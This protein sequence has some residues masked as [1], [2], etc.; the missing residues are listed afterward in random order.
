[1][2]TP[3][4]APRPIAFFD[5]DR[6]LVDGYTGYE[7]SRWLVRVGIFKRRRIAQA[8]FYK[9]LAALHAADAANVLR[10]YEIA[11]GDMAGQHIDTMR[12]HGRYVFDTWFAHRIFRQGLER[13]REH[14]ARGHEVVLLTSGPYMTVDV[15]HERLGTDVCYAMGPRLDERGV[16]LNEARLPI[17]VDHRKLDVAREH[18]RVRGVP[19]AA[20]TFY[21]DSMRDVALLREVGAPRVVNPDR[22]LRREARAR[23]W[24]IEIWK[25]RAPALRELPALAQ[26][27]DAPAPRGG[28]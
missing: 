19:L 18:A 1:M 5:V 2:S 14:R 4:A 28:V 10:M 24:P 8:I 17:T 20:C 23:G 9:I 15:L 16:L 11:L 22:K 26:T 25:E 13:V 7:T 27:A 21:T 3:P 6:T 12:A